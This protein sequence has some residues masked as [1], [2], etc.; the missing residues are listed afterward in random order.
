MQTP[1]LQGIVRRRIL[2]NFRVDPEVIQ[3]HLPPPFHPKLVHGWALAGICLIRLEQLRPLG[4]PAA[5]GTSSENAAHRIAVTWT[6]ESGQAREGV[7]IPR[8]DTG[9]CLNALVGGRFFP[10]E[11]HRA[12]FQVRDDAR[13][14]DLVMDSADGSADVQLRVQ[15][16]D[17]L[18]AASCFESLEA[19]SAF[20]AAGSVGYSA[21]RD[22]AR[23]DGL[24]LRTERWCIEPLD[25]QMVVSRYFEDAAR[26]PP[27]SVAFDSALLMRN[28]P[29]QWYP[30]SPPPCPQPAC[31]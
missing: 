3:R 16:S 19:A 9:S 20:F 1:A 21:T 4:L 2:V 23:F 7:Y 14:I 12:H 27:G 30:V 5:V 10:G 22:V 13:T 28:I 17:R 8:R 25:V 15:M 26:F 31:C 11:H 29:H 6:D 18:P 24:E